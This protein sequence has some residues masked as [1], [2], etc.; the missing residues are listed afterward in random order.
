MRSFKNR[1]E[2]WSNCRSK[3]III[4]FFSGFFLKE[5][6]RL[7]T[8]TTR[9]AMP[10]KKLRKQKKKKTTHPTDIYTCNIY[11]PCWKWI[12]IPC[13]KNIHMLLVL[14][15]VAIANNVA[16][17]VALYPQ[18]LWKKFIVKQV[19]C[20][21]LLLIVYRAETVDTKWWD[22]IDTKILC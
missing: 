17:L 6:D 22:I 14:R 5:I 9:S 8:K 7:I 1:K 2:T 18:Q 10:D 11:F 20:C 4:L 12:S 13:Y 19:M 3:N 16:H 21:S 15:I